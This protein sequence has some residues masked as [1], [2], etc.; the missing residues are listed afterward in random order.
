MNLSH[1]FFFLEGFVGVLH[2]LE[3][4]D[5]AFEDLY[6]GVDFLGDRFKDNHIGD[7]SGKLP[8]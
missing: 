3:V 2:E 1:L 8:V 4:G 7:E 6:I 5:R